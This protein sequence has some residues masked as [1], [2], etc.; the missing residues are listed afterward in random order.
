MCDVHGDQLLADTHDAG[1]RDVFCIRDEKIVE[2]HRV[3][4][5]A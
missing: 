1:Q 4:H 3:A 2:A 5:L